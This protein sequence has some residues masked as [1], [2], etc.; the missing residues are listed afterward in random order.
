MLDIKALETVSMHLCMY[1]HVRIFHDKFQSDGVPFIINGQAVHLRGTL[2]LGCGD[3]PA[4]NLMSGFKNLTS[5]FHKCRSC[6]AI[7]SDIQTKVSLYV[8]TI[9]ASYNMLR[10][11][12][13]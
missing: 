13:A 9:D 12:H 1:T 6:M 11:M 3:N 7:A 5:A 8:A 10:C 2:I 4:A